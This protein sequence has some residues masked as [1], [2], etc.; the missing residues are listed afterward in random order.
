[1]TDTCSH[2]RTRETR[3]SAIGRSSEEHLENYITWKRA[4]EK[5]G[6]AVFP[7]ISADLWEKLIAR[8]DCTLLQGTW[9]LS[10]E[11]DAES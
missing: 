3:R 9:N 6:E 1:M 4:T 11:L 8:A 10:I 2:E 7:F 5:I